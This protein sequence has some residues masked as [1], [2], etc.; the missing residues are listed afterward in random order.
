MKCVLVSKLE[1][2][3]SQLMLYDN[4]KDMVDVLK[5]MAQWSMMWVKN[6]EVLGS[7]LTGGKKFSLAEQ[8]FLVLVPAGGSWQPGNQPSAYKLTWTPWLLKEKEIINEY[9][10]FI[11]VFPLCNPSEG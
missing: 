11:L 6:L 10:V 1:S 4:V 3:I 7:N 9:M 5:C 8:A 2:L